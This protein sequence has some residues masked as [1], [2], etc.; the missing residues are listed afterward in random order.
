MNLEEQRATIHHDGGAGPATHLPSQGDD[1]SYIPI[2][3]WCSGISA[4]MC[5]AVIHCRPLSASSS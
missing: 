1:V 4:L 2:H 3:Y 5:A